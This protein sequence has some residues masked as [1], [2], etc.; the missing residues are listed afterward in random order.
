MA[1]LVLMAV[2]FSIGAAIILLVAFATVYRDMVLPRQSRMAGFVM[3]LAL[4]VTQSWHA[5]LPDAPSYV[6]VMSLWAHASGFYWLFLGVLRPPQ[7]WSWWEWYAPP[8]T[9]LLLM[10][11]P[12]SIAVPLAMTYGTAGAVHLGVLLVRLGP[13]RRWFLLERNVLVLF[14]GMGA[15]IA[16]LGGAYPWLGWQIFFSAYAVLLALGFAL[17]LLLLLRFPDLT[18]KTQEAVRTSYAVS[19]LSNVDR[20]AA[21]DKIK[22]L[23]EDEHVYRNENLDLATLAGMA[24][25]TPHQTSELINTEMAMS[26]SRLLRHYRIEAAKRMLIEERRASVLSVGMAVGFNS[27]SNFYAAFKELTATVPSQFRKDHSGD[28]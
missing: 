24:N 2:G 25:L 12:T 1:S 23:F 9:L 8:A 22:A 10:S 17:V 18:Q 28:P 15:G 4:I 5:R 14:A 21:V 11:L 27:T 20:R 16:L 7:L 3:L 6:Y 26:F 19:T 13:V